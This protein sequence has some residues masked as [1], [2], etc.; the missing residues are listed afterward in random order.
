MEEDKDERWRLREFFV[1][2]FF[3]KKREGVGAL[4]VDGSDDE[5]VG[6]Y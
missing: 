5:E 6:G 2:F 4:P 3:D 1:F